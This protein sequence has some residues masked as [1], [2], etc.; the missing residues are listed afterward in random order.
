MWGCSWMYYGLNIRCSLALTLATVREHWSRTQIWILR[1]TIVDNHVGSHV[2]VVFVCSRRPIARAKLLKS[3]LTKSKL[4]G[5]IF[6]RFRCAINH[7]VTNLN[8]WHSVWHLG[9]AETYINR[10]QK[11]LVTFTS[12]LTWQPKGE[13]DESLLLPVYIRFCCSWFSPIV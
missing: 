9:T 11:P 10:E 7:S 5:R 1:N 13:R 6:E 4:W 12:T 3:H 8:R 2:I